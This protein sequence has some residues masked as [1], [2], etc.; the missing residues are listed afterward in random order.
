MLPYVIV[1]IC[2]YLLGSIPFGYILVRIFRKQDIRQTGSGNIGATNVAR[3]GAKGLAI[4][5]LLLDAGKG[6]AAV[7]V[8][9][10]IFVQSHG[11]CYAVD[12]FLCT[13]C[14]RAAMLAAL[15]A[16]VGHVFPFWLRFKGGKGVATALGA[17]LVIDPVAVGGALVIFAVIVGVSRYVSLGS[18]IAA[19]AFPVLV[20]TIGI[21]HIWAA[22]IWPIYLIAVLVIAKHHQNIRRLLTGTENRLGSKPLPPPQQMEKNA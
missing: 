15:F 7:L 1:A 12:C 21:S 5:T 16:V 2:A 22:T 19:A 20:L 4:A 10:Q 9:H 3:S 18:I 8:G 11:R 14:G 13:P 6:F 17:L